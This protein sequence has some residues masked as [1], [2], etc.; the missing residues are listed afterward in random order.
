MTRQNSLF[1]TPFKTKLQHFEED[2]TLLM[3]QQRLQYHDKVEE[4][5]EEENDTFTQE[6]KGATLPPTLSIQK[7]ALPVSSEAT[8]EA[9]TVKTTEKVVTVIK[10]LPTTYQAKAPLLPPTIELPMGKVIPPV[11]ALPESPNNN[12]Q[13]EESQENKAL[14]NKE[15]LLMEMPTLS[16]EETSATQA[17]VQE[18]EGDEAINK[19]AA[20]LQKKLVRESEQPEQP[21][22]EEQME[23]FVKQFTE[24]VKAYLR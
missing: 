6:Q 14:F 4:E 18:C 2:R 13:S 12:A 21:D 23:Q 22:L 3:H 5:N 11:L 19:F 10:K 20:A 24:E 8:H 16:D 17:C 7:E 15:N 9:A 1:N